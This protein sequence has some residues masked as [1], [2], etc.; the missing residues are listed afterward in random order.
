MICFSFWFVFKPD[1]V[2]G[3]PQCDNGLCRYTPR[4]SSTVCRSAASICD[5]IK[6]IILKFIKFHVLNRLMNVVTV[7][8]CLV[9]QIDSKHLAHCVVLPLAT[10]I[11]H[12][13]KFKFYLIFF[14]VSVMLPKRVPVAMP[15]VLSTMFLHSVSCVVPRPAIVTLL[16]FV[17]FVKNILSLS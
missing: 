9:R 15:S 10:Y 17:S 5:V 2:C 12:K 16:K 7:H 8:H 13:K 11:L 14:L 6:K 4:S 1:K 3:V